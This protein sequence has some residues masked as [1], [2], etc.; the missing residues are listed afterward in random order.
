MADWKSSAKVIYLVKSGK[1]NQS[2][3]SKV[4]PHKDSKASK[5]AAH[6]TMSDQMRAGWKAK[7]KDQGDYALQ[8]NVTFKSQQKVKDIPKKPLPADCKMDSVVEFTEIQVFADK[9]K[10]PSMHTMEVTV[11]QTGMTNY[12]S[13]VDPMPEAHFEVNIKTGH[14]I[15]GKW[16]DHKKRFSIKGWSKNTLKL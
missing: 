11:I 1:V 9:L 5:A 4:I 2:L 10:M 7:E 6:S 14:M 12:G 15:T 3:K 8:L 13:K 16:K